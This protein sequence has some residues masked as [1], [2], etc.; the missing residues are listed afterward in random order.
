LDGPQAGYDT[1]VLRK[2]LWSGLYASLGAA[3]T[4]AARRTAS[5]IWRLATGEEPPTKK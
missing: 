3:A 2:L 5:R 4:L 1:G